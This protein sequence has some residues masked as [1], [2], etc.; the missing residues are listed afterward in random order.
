MIFFSNNKGGDQLWLIHKH[1]SLISYQN[2]TLTVLKNER[3]NY[4]SKI[5]KKN[6]KNGDKNIFTKTFKYKTLKIKNI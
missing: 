3:P 4:K 6:K 5:F 1:T 2:S